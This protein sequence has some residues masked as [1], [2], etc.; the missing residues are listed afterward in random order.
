MHHIQVTFYSCVSA[1]THPESSSVLSQSHCHQCQGMSSDPWSL[2]HTLLPLK[3]FKHMLWSSLFLIFHCAILP[4][5]TCFLNGHS[6]PEP[7]SGIGVLT[8]KN[9]MTDVTCPM[10]WPTDHRNEVDTM[11]FKG[12]YDSK[13]LFPGILWLSYLYFLGVAW[14]LTYRKHS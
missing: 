2:S 9:N 5:A 8:P 7:K 6:F 12:S 11:I 1:P 4:E 10:S 14:C 13:V 3:D